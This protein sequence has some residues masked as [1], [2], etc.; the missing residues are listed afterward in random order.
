M[1]SVANGCI[2]Y[3]MK[4]ANIISNV[5]DI[6]TWLTNVRPDIEQTCGTAGLDAAT[7]A[8]RSAVH[9][10]WGSDWEQ[11]LADHRHLVDEA[12]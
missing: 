2:L 10:A 1:T 5:S 9:P 4:N 12:V 3:L 11:W 6:R 7:E 8:L